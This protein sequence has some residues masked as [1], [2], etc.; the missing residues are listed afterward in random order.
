M[1][2]LVT[3][4]CGFVGRYLVRELAASGH[5]SVGFGL[6][7]PPPDPF[8]PVIRGDILDAQAVADAVRRIRP[9]AAIHL[10]AMAFP[11]DG[12]TQPARMAAVN[13]QGTVH[14]LD[15]VRREA[16]AARL[17]TVSSARI[18]GSRPSAAPLPEEAPLDPDS[19]YAAT[20]AAADLLTLQYARAFGLPAM[21]AR[22]HN[23][24]GPGQPETMSVASFVAQVRRIAAGTAP[25]RLTV[26]NLA[27]T[28]EFLDVRDV[29]R[30]YRLLLEK[31]RPGQAYNIA[32]GRPVSLASLVDTLA[33]LAGVNPARDVDP[34]RFRATDASAPLDTRRL[35]RDTGWTPAFPLEATLR[36]MLAG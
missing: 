29:V 10:A 4:A 21:T 12:E 18:Y 36:D 9:D 15:A 26:G 11:P 20:K 13:I 35:V 30:A 5:T 14:L 33:R 32:S 23:H 1:R 7:P 22:P 8:C 19:L 28:R 2:V 16:P 25:P 6:E 3:G 24:T 31:G 34:A 27:S 17:L